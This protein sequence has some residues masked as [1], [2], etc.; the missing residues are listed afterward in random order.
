MHVAR[1]TSSVRSRYPSTRSI[2]SLICSVSS[3][4]SQGSSHIYTCNAKHKQTWFLSTWMFQPEYFTSNRSFNEYSSTYSTHRL[5]LVHALTIHPREMQ[6]MS[7]LSHDAGSYE[8]LYEVDSSSGDV[9]IYTG[10]W[11]THTRCIYR[12]DSS[13]MSTRIKQVW[14]LVW[15]FRIKPLSKKQ[16][17]FDFQHT[18][19]PSWLFILER[20]K[21]Y[22]HRTTTHTAM[23]QYTK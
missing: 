6:T 9:V 7:S 22:D 3:W 2:V 5:V 11:Q 8:T 21:L 12:I 19:R 18:Q 4:F 20:Y 17:F 1:T 10:L 16:V 15:V 14:Y 13:M 23:I